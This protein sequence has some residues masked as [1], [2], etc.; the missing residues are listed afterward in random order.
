MAIPIFSN[1]SIMFA[2]IVSW[3]NSLMNETGMLPFWLGAVNV[4]L[5]VRFLLMPIL[6]RSLGSDSVSSRNGKVNNRSQ[7]KITKGRAK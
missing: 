3:F 6:G 1:I 2:H 7:L 4:A 5:C